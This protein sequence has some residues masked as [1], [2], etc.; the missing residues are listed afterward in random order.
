M[1]LFWGKKNPAEKWGGKKISCRAFRREKNI[2]PTRL[3]EKKILAHQ[4]SKMV[5]PLEL[6][7]IPLQTQLIGKT[8]VKDVFWGMTEWPLNTCWP[9]H[10]GLT[11]LGVYQENQ[12]G[13]NTSEI[14]IARQVDP[15]EGSTKCLPH[16]VQKRKQK[17]AKCCGQCLYC[18]CVVHLDKVTFKSRWRK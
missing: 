1:T 5:G 3:L 12:D 6:T 9:F 8:T 18:A 2:L 11:N 15:A 14:S 16:L 13:D 7:L 10:T 4:K 17:S